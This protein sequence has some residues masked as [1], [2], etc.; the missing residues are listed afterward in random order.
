MCGEKSLAKNGIYFT[1][2]DDQ[3]LEHTITYVMGLF[4]ISWDRHI[5]DV[6]DSSFSYEL[7]YLQLK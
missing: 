2:L 7:N 1:L 5:W 4:H 3:S 6:I